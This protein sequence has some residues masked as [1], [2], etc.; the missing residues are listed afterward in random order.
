MS[1][2][3][4]ATKSDLDALENRILDALGGLAK[5]SDVDALGSKIDNLMSTIEDRFGAL[6]GRLGGIESTLSDH[7]AALRRIEDLL[8]GT[9]GRIS[10]I[11][12]AISNIV[13]S[14]VSLI[15]DPIVAA[16]NAQRAL[17]EGLLNS[18]RSLIEGVFDSI[19]EI[20]RAA[21][22]FIVETIRGLFDSI[23]AFIEG[24][25]A[26]VR[27][28]IRD[29][30]SEIGN[31]LNVALETRSGVNTANSRIR[32]V[33]SAVN[34][35]QQDLDDIQGAISAVN[36]RVVE[37]RNG[38]AVV[39]DRLFSVQGVVNSINGRTS[40]MQ[41]TL[42]TVNERVQRILD[43][44]DGILGRLGSIQG[45]LDSLRS[46][47]S[48]IENAVNALESEINGL[49]GEV[50]DYSL[51]C[52]NN[53]HTVKSALAAVAC[54]AL[55]KGDD[56]EDF[57]DGDSGGAGAGQ[58]WEELTD[59]DLL[60]R[61]AKVT[62][63]PDYPLT[64]PVSLLVGEAGEKTIE[65]TPQFIDWAMIQ[66]DALIGDFPIK[67]EVITGYKKNSDGSAGDAIVEEKEV[68]SISEVL[69][70]LYFESKDL[71]RVVGVADFPGS[72]PKYLLSDDKYKGKTT[73]ESIPGFL[74]WLTNQMD[75]LAG[76]F[77]IEV[78]VKSSEPNP[79]AP[80]Q[81]QEVEKKVKLRNISETMAELYTQGFYLTTMQH[82]QTNALVRTGTE[83][84][85]LKVAV[86][87]AQDLIMAANEFLGF[88]LKKKQRKTNFS[89]TPK[90]SKKEK[91]TLVDFLTNYEG[92]YQGWEFDD[93]E[94]L[95]EYLPQLLYGVSL[96]KAATLR[97]KE[98][99]DTLQDQVE[100]VLKDTRTDWE[101]FKDL[102]NNPDS[103]FNQNEDLK[104]R[105]RD[106]NVE[107]E[108]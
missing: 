106:R 84:M 34:A 5:K 61:I 88:R 39:D 44:Q 75:A 104:F 8:E 40:E 81:Y 32:D 1:C 66:L 49:P 33:D 57:G 96:I 52:G 94:I 42:G 103:E 85:S 4:L 30:D 22:D 87:V 45:A 19:G 54:P 92:K 51:S 62:G 68:F 102:V 7:G 80:G 20:I 98:D 13:E 83:L 108:D 29:V 91:Y 21:R 23:E 46:T 43:Y 93:R 86:L 58:N 25:F 15:R 11:W 55:P 31:L 101:K 12:D 78:D 59:R 38:V 79:N 24:A 60:E 65:S 27:S 16:I 3:N 18:L 37:V 89:F 107:G 56:G 67:G 99:I 76:E 17:I 6:N 2:P 73:L 14:L 48:E 70:D 50:W 41:G 63:V 69:A 97:G 47:L 9:N 71:S 10:N 74:L 77:P 95:I 90:T 72:V 28:L 26:T 36:S 35:L 100:E 82:A 105:V 64:L 53:S